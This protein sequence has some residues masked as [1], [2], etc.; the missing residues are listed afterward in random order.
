MRPSLPRTL[1]VFVSFAALVACS[2][3]LPVEEEGG[4]TGSSGSSGSSGF[5]GGG[6]SSG[7]GGSSGNGCGEVALESKKTPVDVIL[8]IDTSGS[9]D[10]EI[11][12]V[13]ANI[14][15]FAGKLSM[16][17]LDFHV[18]VLGG[19][20]GGQ[21]QLVV[22]EP[23]AGPNGAN[24]S[25]TFNHLTARVDSNNAWQV[26]QSTHTQWKGFTREDA[27]KVFIVFSDDEANYSG[28]VAKFDSDLLAK[29]GFGTAQ[30]R[31]YTFNAVVG[32]QEGTAIT[33]TTKC[34]SAATPGTRH[35]QLATLTGGLVDSICKTDFSGIFDSISKGVAN[36]LAC[37]ASLPSGPGADPTRV[38]VAAAEEQFVP[39]TDASKCSANPNGWYF[40]TP[41]KDHVKLCDGACT[42]A[43]TVAKLNIAVGCTSQT[44]R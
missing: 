14:N 22:P 1:G 20:D 19:R 41:E 4:P 36:Q 17:G 27:F 40:D 25:P 12:E 16:S 42:K 15:T 2:A 30:A 33:A 34:G 31:K 23:L 29:G 26:I 8:A 38:V 10:E 6:S 35:R 7:A 32:W 24:K 44:P 3:A 21:N 18:I 13:R 5:G 43:R 28:G 39:V 11:A 37:D 9:M